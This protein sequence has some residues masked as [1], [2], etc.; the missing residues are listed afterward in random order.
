MVILWWSLMPQVAKKITDIQ[1]RNLKQ[2]GLHR[3]GGEVVLS[4]KVA[5]SGNRTFILRAKVGNKSTDIKLGDYPPMTLAQARERTKEC[6]SEINKGLDPTGERKRCHAALAAEQARYMT[7]KGA[8]KQLDI[9]KGVWNAP[10]PN[11][12]T[13]KYQVYPLGKTAV[14]FLKNH[15]QSFEKTPAE[16]M[17]VFPYPTGRVLSDTSL[18][19]VMKAVHAAAKEKCVIP[20]KNGAPCLTA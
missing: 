4:L 3:I 17:W 8:S 9:E 15:K 1:L 20:F 10:A 14:A 13:K 7:F 12:K 18:S 16:D 2:T 6:R 19:N 11:M 5:L